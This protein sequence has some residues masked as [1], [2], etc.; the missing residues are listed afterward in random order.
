MRVDTIPPTL[1]VASG[2]DAAWNHIHDLNGTLSGTFL[3]VWPV[4][5]A[6]VFTYLLS[7]WA[8]DSYVRLSL[9]KPP[10]ARPTDNSSG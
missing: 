7:R 9:A 6:A 8:C 5:I 2:A 4:V 1:A 10:A 3:F